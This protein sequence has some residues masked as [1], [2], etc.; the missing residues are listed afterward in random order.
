MKLFQSLSATLISIIVFVACS[1]A[2]DKEATGSTADSPAETGIVNTGETGKQDLEANKQIIRAYIQSLYGD[3][4]STA[5]DK[6]V[7][8]NIKQHNPLL[9]DG[10][11]WLKTNLR[12]FLE[13]PN[14]NK[15]KV[16]IKQMAAEGDR[17]W[18]FIREVA[19]NGNVYA[20]IEIFRIENG[21]IAENWLVSMDEPKTS[22]NKNG[23]F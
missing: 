21:K 4:D 5:I 14:I 8:D 13:N 7:A 16:D 20:R 2:S 19:P 3:K 10:K 22:A 11:A 9:Q 6:Y 1:N 12:P 23:I 18:V 17:V 15:V